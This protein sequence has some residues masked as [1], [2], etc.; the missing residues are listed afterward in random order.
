MSNKLEATFHGG[1]MDYT[2]LLGPKYSNKKEEPNERP[3]TVTSVPTETDR[4]RPAVI[5]G[6]ESTPEHKPTNS[7]SRRK[8]S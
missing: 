7:T 3:D 1:T 2:D 5:E 6:S 8:R 4:P